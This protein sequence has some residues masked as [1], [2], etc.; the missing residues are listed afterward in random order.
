MIFQTA[1]S[2]SA[3]TNEQ[4]QKYSDSKSERKIERERKR[5]IGFEKRP[6]AVAAVD[7]LTTNKHT[8]HY[9]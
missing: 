1:A 2:Q 9:R 7:A 5:N 3:S 6:V 8:P 4:N